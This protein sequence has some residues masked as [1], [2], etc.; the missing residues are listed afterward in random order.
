LSQII[1]ESNST[2]FAEAAVRLLGLVR[3]ATM[4]LLDGLT[5][6]LSSSQVSIRR[7]AAKAL[8]WVG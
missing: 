3:S 8:G 6:L 5:V 1:E 4:D 7:A 2:D